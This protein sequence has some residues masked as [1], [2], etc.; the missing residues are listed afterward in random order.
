[1]A[2]L[3]KGIIVCLGAFGQKLLDGFEI[4]ALGCRGSAEHFPEG[5]HGAAGGGLPVVPLVNDLADGRAVRLSLFACR[6]HGFEQG[7]LHGFRV[8]GGKEDAR[9]AVVGAL[10]EGGHVAC[11]HGHAVGVGHEQHTAAVDLPVREQ[12]EIRVADKLRDLLLGHAGVVKLHTVTDAVL[13]DEGCV[14][15]RVELRVLL[16][17]DHEAA[18]GPVLLVH[19]GDGLEQDVHAL[20]GADAP[21]VEKMH[22]LVV[23]PRVFVH[24]VGGIEAAGDDADLLVRDV[25]F[26]LEVLFGRVVVDDQQVAGTVKASVELGVAGGGLVGQDVVH[27]HDQQAVVLSRLL[28]ELHLR[29]GLLEALDV[30]HVIVPGAD[31][32][33][34]LHEGAS[35]VQDR[36]R[37]ALAAVI[38]AA[39]PADAGLL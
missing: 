35:V 21:E 32:V 10:H 14:V 25:E 22:A 17:T 36:R 18:A 33:L 9:L 24:A 15:R 29:R 20:V 34:Q 30:Q 19:Q 23:V 3:R 8:F 26:V 37:L 6:V 5:A 12:Q 1:M 13:P 11:H 28:V 38:E 2:V 27:R 31:L 39:L 16:A 4:G 7:V